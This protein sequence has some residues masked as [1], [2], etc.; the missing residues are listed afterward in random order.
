MK[1]AEIQIQISIRRGD[2]KAFE[3][4]FNRYYRPLCLHAN[5]V[6]N[7]MDLAEDIVQEFFYQYWKNRE[8]TSVRISLEAYLYRS[9][10]NNAVHSLKQLTTKKK[11]LEESFGRD[12]PQLVEEQRIGL[13]ELRSI[14][15]NTLL[16]LPER[17]A[18]I[19][20][21]SRFE[22]KKY[23]EIAESLSISVKTVEA[24]MGKALQQFRD[25]LGQYR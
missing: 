2:I 7:D 22:G 25:S 17:C 15:E 20:S 23:R 5:K 3:S 4:L 12:F 10:H 24:E 8:S 1:V 18:L 11:H 6:I 21:M 14:I 9:V 13:K 16:N 19:F